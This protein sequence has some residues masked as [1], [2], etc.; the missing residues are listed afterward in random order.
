MLLELLVLIQPTMPKRKF[1]SNLIVRYALAS[2]VKMQ[3]TCAFMV[4]LNK[5][6]EKVI[7]ANAVRVND[8]CAV[9]VKTTYDV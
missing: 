4:L 7:E 6:R 9:R 1:Y 8:A 2:T 3:N 5:Q